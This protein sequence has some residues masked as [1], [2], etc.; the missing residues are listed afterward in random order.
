MLPWEKHLAPQLDDY[1][2]VAHRV[3]DELISDMVLGRSMVNGILAKAKSMSLTDMQAKVASVLSTVVDVD[4]S[5][6]VEAAILDGIDTA[7]DAALLKAAKALLPTGAAPASLE[8]A[9]IHLASLQKSSVHQMAK[10]AAKRKVQCVVEIV[11]GMQE[12]VGPDMSFAAGDG[13]YADVLNQLQYF[14]ESDGK[15]GKDALKK[16]FGEMGELMAAD[17]TK[18]GLSQL[19]PFHVFGWLL[20]ADSR[21]KVGEWVK[22]EALRAFRQPIDDL[23]IR[24]SFSRYVNLEMGSVYAESLDV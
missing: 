21:K 22:I 10:P 11:L 17:S 19:E 12:N 7:M 24:V 14:C 20:D 9:S 4:P 16:L 1:K 23:D 18:V 2:D 3:P 5:F 15:F 8:Q 13:F 6:K